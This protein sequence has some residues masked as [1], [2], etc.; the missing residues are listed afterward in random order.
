MLSIFTLCDERGKI[1]K[2]Y[3]FSTL[4]IYH[5]DNYVHTIKDREKVWWP[6]DVSGKTAFTDL[7]SI[8]RLCVAILVFDFY[9]KK[10]NHQTTGW[11]ISNC[12]MKFLSKILGS[13]CHSDFRAHIVCVYYIHICN[14][15]KATEILPE[16]CV[17][18][19]SDHK[20]ISQRPTKIFRI[21]LACTWHQ[22]NKI[23]SCHYS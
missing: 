6:S 4:C 8:Y 14:A 9:V 10:K 11:N 1:Y 22:Q 20:N 15:R 19:N 17:H 16:L 18:T 2:T 12:Y 13:I 5:H 23:M 7:Q 21:K 3:H